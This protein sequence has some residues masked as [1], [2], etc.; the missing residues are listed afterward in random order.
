MARQLKLQIELKLV[1]SW[2]W[3]GEIILDYPEPDVVE[4]A[5]KYNEALWKESECLEYAWVCT[6]QNIVT[7]IYQDWC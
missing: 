3:G 6:S 1:T 5:L 7:L 4:S 2:S